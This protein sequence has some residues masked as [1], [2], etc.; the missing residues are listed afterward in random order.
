MVS[1]RQQSK[2][3]NRRNKKAVQPEN[4]V[5]EILAKRY[6]GISLF[7]L[8]MLLLAAAIIFTGVK[9][10]L[11]VQQYHQ[12]YKNLQLLKK[13]YLQ[14]QIEHNRLMIEQQTFSATPQI[15]A[16]AVA[17]L[18]MYSPTV[19]DKIIVQPQAMSANAQSS[20]QVAQQGEAQ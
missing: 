7:M 3:P 19:K 9:S 14:L 10:A 17:E 16:R 15:A 1:K 12:D 13:Q 11:Q 2:S 6:G 8:V 5:V 20:E 18:N 4:E